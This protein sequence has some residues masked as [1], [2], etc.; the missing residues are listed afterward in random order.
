MVEPVSLIHKQLNNLEKWVVAKRESQGK[1][2]GISDWKGKFKNASAWQFESENES[3]A[4]QQ[5]NWSES[6]HVMQQSVK[7]SE[8]IYYGIHQLISIQQEMHWGGEQEN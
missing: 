8:L 5:R 6:Q 1:E 7:C 3:V 2:F 4:P